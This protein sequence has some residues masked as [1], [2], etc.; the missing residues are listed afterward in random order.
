MKRT[1]ALFAVLLLLGRL[2]AQ[3][4][5][6]A[7]NLAPRM[8]SDGKIVDA[9]DGRT[10]QFGNK[11]YW[12]GT[13]YGATN[14]FT[15]ANEYVSY[16]TTDFKT[17]KPEGSLLP[18]KPAGV[19]YRPHVVYNQKNGKYV[20]WYNWY[21]KLWDGQFGVAV[22]DAPQG[23]FTIV[24]DNVKVKHSNLGVGDLGVFVDDDGKAYLSYN[25]I[26]GHKVSVEELDENYTA[27]TLRGSAFVAE[28]CEAGSMFKRN[29]VYYL[30]TDYTCCFCTQGS[31]ARVFTASSPLGPF[32]Y[33]QNINRY[34]GAAAPVLNDG[35]RNDN[36]FETLWAKEQNAVEVWMEK[37]EKI[38]SLTLHQFTGNRSGQCGDVNN[39]AVHEPILSFPF[40]LQYFS[41]G[42]W[43]PLAVSDS[44]IRTG[45]MQIVYN[46]RFPPIETERLRV[47]PVY[48]DS[49]SYLHLSEIELNAKERFSV[50][51]TG[52]GEGKP[53]IPAQQAY[54]IELNTKG[55]KAYVWT[56]DLWG[57]ASDNIKGHDYQFWS[58]PLRFYANGLM[59]PLQ[60][61]DEWKTKLKN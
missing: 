53:I 16:S 28:H 32:A 55:G 60:W 44:S 48:R 54:V 57:S 41:E 38:S 15:T 6:I 43:K 12:Y 5:F 35:H 59:A 14:G 45:S 19:Y 7:D 9:H 34:P 30:L 3:K 52:K 39:P 27:S 17:W 31:G 49:S 20:L 10:I 42:E 33:R 61:V 46:Y 58:A 56:G 51:K 37:P 23:P 22:A 24:S 47:V 36:L 40:A 29:G 50:F 1:I 25:T 11:F 4:N 26:Q 2:Q 18:Q 21:P 8:D 13:R